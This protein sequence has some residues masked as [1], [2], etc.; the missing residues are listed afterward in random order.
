MSRGVWRPKFWGYAPKSAPVGSMVAARFNPDR[1][2][3]NERAEAKGNGV[4]FP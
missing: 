2:R 1:L 3:Y 4:A